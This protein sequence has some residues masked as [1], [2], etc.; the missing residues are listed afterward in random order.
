MAD[1]QVGADEESGKQPPRSVAEI[2]ADIEQTRQHLVA[3]LESLK[4]QTQPQ[5][6]VAKA[7]KQA[8]SVILDE[9]GR[10]RTERVAVVV[11]VV[12]GLFILT[13]AAKARGDRRRMEELARVVWVPVP[14][15]AV[16]PELRPIARNAAELAPVLVDSVPAIGPA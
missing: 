1:K 10:V 14:R 2:Q 9:Q 15:S 8:S 7:K 6:L 5:V 13:R 12:V 3:S 11:G 16:A 4:E